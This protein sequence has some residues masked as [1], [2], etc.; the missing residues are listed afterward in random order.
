MKTGDAR[1]RIQ[2][3]LL[4]GQ[5]D[6]LPAAGCVDTV[7]EKVSSGKYRPSLPLLRTRLR[8]DD[9]L[10]GPGMGTAHSSG[11]RRVGGGL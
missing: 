7:P 4:H 8:P 1:F 11:S 10:M 9:L 2:N 3:P 6:A 5:V